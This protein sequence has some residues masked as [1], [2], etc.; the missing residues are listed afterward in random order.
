MHR[1]G[2]EC[3]IVYGAYQEMY[4]QNARYLSGYTD[5]LQFYVILPAQAEP[6]LLTHSAP[7]VQNARQVSAIRDTRWGGS[8]IAETVADR[9]RELGLEHGR[10]GLAGIESLRDIS[11]PVEHWRTLRERLPAADIRVVTTLLEEIRVE[12]SAEEVAFLWRG[13]AATDRAIAAFA[14]AAK[15]GRREYEV[16]AAIRCAGYESGGTPSFAYLGS[17]PMD[18]PAG[19]Y[20]AFAPSTRVLTQGDVLLAETAVSYGGYSGSAGRTLTLGPPSAE[21]RELYEVALETYR[22]MVAALRPG[23]TDADLLEATRPIADAGLTVQFPIVKGWDNKIERPW[24]GLAGDP[25][26]PTIPCVVRPNQVLAIG[27]NPC[28]RDL[29][30]GVFLANL[31]LVTNEGNV[32]LQ[33]YPTDLIVRDGSSVAR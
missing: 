21:Y 14:E 5:L 27:P 3:L 23:A 30:A 31:H 6:T 1:E 28:T 10:V 2:L 22:R 32:C 11:V 9:I 12:K 25:N 17:T 8:R 4:Q 19:A 20:P 33:K 29:Q 15:V 24:I 16:L 26:W 13:A 18:A 7:Q